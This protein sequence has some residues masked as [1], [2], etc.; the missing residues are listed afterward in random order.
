[1]SYRKQKK[2]EAENRFKYLGLFVL[3]WDRLLVWSHGSPIFGGCLMI[4]FLTLMRL[5]LILATEKLRQIMS[6]NFWSI[7][8]S[9]TR[10]KIF[11]G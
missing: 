9:T 2:L 6:A 7:G 5:C 4:T 10:R 1:M 3:V 11:A 8:K